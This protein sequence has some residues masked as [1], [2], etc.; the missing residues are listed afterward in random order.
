MIS[1][2]L[3]DYILCEA[4]CFPK[5]HVHVVLCISYQALTELNT[6]QYRI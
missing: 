2:K 3:F 1:I 5:A 6:G 4:T